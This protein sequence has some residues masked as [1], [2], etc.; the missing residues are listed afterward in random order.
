M[1]PWGDEGPTEAFVLKV[2][3]NGELAMDNVKELRVNM[4]R[5]MRVPKV[6]NSNPNQP[7]L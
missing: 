1:V 5:A 3:L 7:Q 4:M 6:T 2:A